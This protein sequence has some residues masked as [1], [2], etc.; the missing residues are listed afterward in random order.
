MI[1]EKH[2]HIYSYQ[3][4]AKCILWNS[5][6][7]LSDYLSTSVEQ[8]PPKFNPQN[9]CPVEK[10]FLEKSPPAHILG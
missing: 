6:L 5:P 7:A 8:S 2:F 3:I 1:V 9:L 10:V 4:T